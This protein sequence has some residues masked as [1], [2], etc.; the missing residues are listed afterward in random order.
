MNLLQTRRCVGLVATGL[1]LAFSSA[2]A[3]DPL[4]RPPSVVER[5]KA[6]ESSLDQQ[7]QALGP[8]DERALGPLQTGQGSDRQIVCFKLLLGC[9]GSSTRT[10][11]GTALAATIPQPDVDAIGTGTASSSAAGRPGAATTL[12]MNGVAGPRDRNAPHRVL[13]LQQPDLQKLIPQPAMQSVLANADRTEREMNEPPETV[14]V[15]ADAAS[16]DVPSGLA[17]L[18]WA[19]KNPS[20]AWRVLF[21]N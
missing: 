18:W 1:L 21:P 9:I 6:T 8:L 17:G 12:A 16:P 19:V 4:P 14:Q 2:H 5:D 3:Q 7:Q 13:D 11:T 20:Q 10:P 15:E